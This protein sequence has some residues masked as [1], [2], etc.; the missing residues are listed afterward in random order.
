MIKE[1]EKFLNGEDIV[2]SL[3]ES[4][5]QNDYFELLTSKICYDSYR[6]ELNRIYWLSTIIYR[7]TFVEYFHDLTP[8]KSLELKKDNLMIYIPFLMFSSELC[9]ILKSKY[10]YTSLLS[11]IARQMIEQICV[12]KEIEFE[13]ISEFKIVEAMIQ[14]HNIHVGANPIDIENLN[15]RNK[16][17]LKVFNTHRSYGKLAKKYGYSFMY[18]LYSGDIHHISTIDKLIPQGKNTYNQYNDIYIKCLLSLTKESL[19]F[20]NNICNGLTKEE[21]EKINSIDY[22]E[23]S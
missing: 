21:I 9:K 4:M 11:T 3:H 7:L 16:G 19:L 20:V 17:I 5:F 23:L 1:I 6:V 22:V 10:I 12:A 8:G 14:S 15:E 13:N 2:D 18:H